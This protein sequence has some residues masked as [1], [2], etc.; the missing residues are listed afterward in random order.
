MATLTALAAGHGWTAGDLNTQGYFAMVPA[1]QKMFF[2]D[3]RPYNSSIN[4]SGYHK[5]DFINTKLT[6]AA[7]GALAGTTEAALGAD[8]RTAA[9]TAAIF[10]LFP[11]GR[12]SENAC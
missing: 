10:S 2:S 11:V 8:P 6:G 3:G 7:S 4:S 1:W 5:L 9:E 12:A